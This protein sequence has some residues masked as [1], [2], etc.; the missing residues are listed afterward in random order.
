VIL[1]TRWRRGFLRGYCLI[2]F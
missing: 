2:L 1:S